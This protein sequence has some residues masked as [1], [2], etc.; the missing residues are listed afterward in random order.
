M[1][2]CFFLLNYNSL[3]KAIDKITS[4]SGMGISPK[5]ITVST[6]WLL[7]QIKK[8]GDDKVKFKKAIST[9]RAID[10]VRFEIMPD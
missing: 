4:K 8:L 10:K 3:L 5:R 1:G 9:F 2:M 7:K 6:V